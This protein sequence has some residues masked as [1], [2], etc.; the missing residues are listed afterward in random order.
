MDK[1]KGCE[2]K[3][4][5]EINEELQAANEHC[6]RLEKYKSRNVGNCPSDLQDY[7]MA[8][9]KRNNLQY[10]LNQA[11]KAKQALCKHNWHETAFGKKWWTPGTWQFTCQRCNKMNQVYMGVDRA[12]A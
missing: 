3:S 9:R 6:A 4:I 8:W 11:I 7:D 5:E 2:M 1:D 12:T 10:Q